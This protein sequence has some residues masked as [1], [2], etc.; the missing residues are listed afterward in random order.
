MSNM[1]WVKSGA[2]YSFHVK[3]QLS[4]N[5]VNGAASAVAERS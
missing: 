1:L 3:H 2:F 5:D 4:K